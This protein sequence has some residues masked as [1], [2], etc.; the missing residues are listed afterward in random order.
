MQQVRALVTRWGSNIDPR[1]LICIL[2]ALNVYWTVTLG[3]FDRQFRQVAG[4]PLLD[5]QNDLDPG[6]IITPTRVMEQIATYGQEA[7]TLYWSFFILDNIMPQLTFGSFALLWVYFLRSNP[8]RFTGALLGS[9]FIVLPLG[10]GVFD[11]LENLGYIVAIHAYPEAITLPAIYAGLLFKWLKAACL[12]PTF[13]CTAVLAAYH[14]Y[15]RVRRR[16]AAAPAAPVER[17]SVEVP[18]ISNQ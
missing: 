5:L 4:Y 6:R 8:H 11:W 18:S 12:F 10:V 17:G 7:K 3:A 1:L 9:S 15:G 2:V 16:F 13:L 14:L